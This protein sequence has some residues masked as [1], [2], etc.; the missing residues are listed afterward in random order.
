MKIRDN[1][2]GIVMD[3]NWVELDLGEGDMKEECPVCGSEDGDQ[4][5]DLAPAWEMGKWAHIERL[6]AT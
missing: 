1:Y 3:K 6:T 5:H 2:T 4:C